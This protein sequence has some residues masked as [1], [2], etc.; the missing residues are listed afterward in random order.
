[1]SKLIL[2]DAKTIEK[3]L[4]LLGFIKQRQKGSHAFYKHE[5]GRCTVIP[6]HSSKVIS[7]PLMRKILNEINLDVE[8]YNNLIEKL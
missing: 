2:K 5:N 4:I 1:M 6:F 3:L 7:R 8:E